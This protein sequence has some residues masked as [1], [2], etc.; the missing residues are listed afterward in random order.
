VEDLQKT[1]QRS[2]LTYT[3]THS[4]K[5]RAP[6]NEGFANL[7]GTIDLERGVIHTPA[8]GMRFVRSGR[9]VGSF[10]FNLESIRLEHGLGLIQAMFL[11][12]EYQW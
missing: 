11:T 9:L 2:G 8:K 7:V 10:S 4:E 1:S 6:V 5:I 12:R 3:G